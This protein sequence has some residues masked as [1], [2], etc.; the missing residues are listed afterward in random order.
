MRGGTDK[1]TKNALDRL[2][3]GSVQLMYELTNRVDWKCDV[4]AIHSDILENTN[5]LFVKNR[6]KH[7]LLHVLRVYA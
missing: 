1:K 4:W 7:E 3:V 6:F 5:H 2:Y